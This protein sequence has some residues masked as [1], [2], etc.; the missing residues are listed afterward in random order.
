MSNLCDPIDG[1]PPGSPVPGILQ[2]RTLEWAA[3]SFSN[4]LLRDDLTERV[5]SYTDSVKALLGGT[6]EAEEVWT[7]SR[8]LLC[9]ALRVST[10]PRCIRSQYSPSQIC[11]NF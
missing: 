11:S 5:K 1:S 2:A 6:G 9:W 7:L 8:A 3:T 4:T 10:L